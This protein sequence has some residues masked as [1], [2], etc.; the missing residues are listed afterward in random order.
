MSLRKKP[1]APARIERCMSSGFAKLDRT[2]NR[3][4]GTIERTPSMTWERSSVELS[5]PK[6]MSCGRRRLS[7]AGFIAGP[8]P[9][10]VD[11]GILVEQRS[12]GFGD[13]RLALDD[14]RLERDEIS[15][16]HVYRGLL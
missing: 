5:I 9:H 16:N 6:M 1:S 15:C 13:E 12:Q 7:S 10:D 2:T 14:D 3:T 4:S 11:R 8:S